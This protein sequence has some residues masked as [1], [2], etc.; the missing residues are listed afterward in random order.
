MINAGYDKTLATKALVL[1]PPP[2]GIFELWEMAE[3]EKA[4]IAAAVEE[5]VAAAMATAE[6]LGEDPYAAE[7]RIRADAAV[8]AAEAELITLASGKTKKRRKVDDG[9]GLA[10]DWL[11][12]QIGGGLRLTKDQR[13]RLAEEEREAG[14]LRDLEAERI[15]QES[16]GLGST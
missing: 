10:R 16:M 3:K 2:D 8:A 13:R 11:A 12:E 6:Q 4:A 7:E 14:R 15:L 1:Y 9:M 5:E